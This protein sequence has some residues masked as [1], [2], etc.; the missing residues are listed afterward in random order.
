MELDLL[1]D[2]TLRIVTPISFLVF[3]FLPL[4]LGMKIL[5]LSLTIYFLIIFI[6]CTYWANEWHKERKFIIGFLVSLFHAFIFILGG[7]IGLALA[8]I[9]LKL[10][11]LLLDYI[12]GLLIF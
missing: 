4:A 7:S 9:A 11:P 12:K 5:L 2:K 6:L 10:Y 3:L 1:E 8:Q